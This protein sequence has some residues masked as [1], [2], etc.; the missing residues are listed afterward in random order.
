MTA[1]LYILVY[2]CIFLHILVNPC[3]HILVYPCVSLCIHILVYPCVSLHI[4]VYPCVYPVTAHLCIFTAFQF[5]PLLPDG[6]LNPKPHCVN[7]GSNFLPTNKQVLWVP[8]IY[9][10]VKQ[11]PSLAICHLCMKKLGNYKYSVISSYL[12]WSFVFV[13]CQTN[14]NPNA[15]KLIWAIN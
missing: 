7:V 2:P 10:A 12:P 5:P 3:I 9:E 11:T 14:A 1:L 8:A 4:L 6:S 13:S 15:N